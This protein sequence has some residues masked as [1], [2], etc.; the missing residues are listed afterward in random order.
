VFESEANEAAAVTVLN[1]PEIDGLMLVLPYAPDANYGMVTTKPMLRRLRDLSARLAKPIAFSLMSLPSLLCKVRDEEAFPYFVTPE[2]GIEALAASRDFWRRRT[3]VQEKPARIEVDRDQVERLLAG[4]AGKLTTLDACR[5]LQAYGIP[6]AEAAL[7]RSPE[8]A[9]QAARRLGYPVALKIESA[10]ISHKSDI[11]GVAVGLRDD[12]AVRE[13]YR[14]IMEESARVAPGARLDG[15]LVQSMAQGR[16]V[17]LGARQYENF[18]PVVMF[19]LG[20]I[21]VEVLKD[22]SFRVAPI[23]QRESEEMVREIRAVRILEGVRGQPPTDMGF[24]S[25][26]LVRLAQLVSDFPQILEIDA[27]PVMVFPEGK[28]GLAVDARIMVGDPVTP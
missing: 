26:C 8:E 23:T 19:G 18:G 12:Q 9:V 10:D 4:S 28:G 6:V 2:D 22:V 25:G 13:G 27:N 14:S 1:V 3:E 5:V 7:S 17:I 20:G 15:V 21:H 24:L 11:G 16:E